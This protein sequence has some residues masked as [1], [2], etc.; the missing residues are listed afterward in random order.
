MS[1]R[2]SIRMMMHLRVWSQQ[3][4]HENKNAMIHLIYCWTMMIVKM[5]DETMRFWKSGKNVFQYRSV[6]FDWESSATIDVDGG[7]GGA[8]FNIV[9]V[10]AVELL[11]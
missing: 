8:W 2:E 6:Q 4:I 11:E 7:N 1:I 9:F 5:Q 3:I 10:V